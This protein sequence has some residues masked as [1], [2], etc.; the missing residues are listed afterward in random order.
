M[1]QKI[2]IFISGRGSNMCALAQKVQN[3]ELKANI[4]YVISD[5]PQACGLK[6]AQDLGL[7]T[8]ILSWKKQPILSLIHQLKQDGIDYIIL[9]G[10]MRILPAYFI[11]EFP[12]RIINIHPS[13]LPRYKGLSAME[14]CFEAGDDYGGISIHYVD[15]GI[16]TGPL[17]AQFKVKRY[18]DDR[19]EDFQNRM[20]Q[21]EHKIYAKTLQ[22]IFTRSL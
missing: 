3:G 5:N 16:D 10:F 9:A 7:K 19:L 18:A 20:H 11:A 21:C 2:A 1:P 14:R 17:I 8:Q 4:A 13:L 6:K 15:E 12:S 22:Q